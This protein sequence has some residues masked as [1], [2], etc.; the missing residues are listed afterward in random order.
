VKHAAVEEPVAEAY[1][2]QVLEKDDDVDDVKD[3][4]HVGKLKFRRH[5]DDSYRMGG[6]GNSLDDYAIIDTRND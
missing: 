2:G 1:H 6:D 5:I 3:E 4:W